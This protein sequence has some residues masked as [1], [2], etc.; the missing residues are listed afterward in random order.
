MI[1]QSNPKAAYLSHRA[2]IDAAI[3]RVLESGWYILGQEV[4]A[5]EREFAEY[6]GVAHA[7]GVA[8]GTD[9]LVLSLKACGVGPGDLV[10]TVAHTAVATVTAIDL[11]GA[12]PVF[13]D[14][15][16][17]TYNMDPQR[18]EEAIAGAVT[19]GLGLARAVIPVHL[20]GAAAPIDTIAQIARAYGLRLIEDCAQST[21][22]EFADTKTGA[23]GDLGAFSFYPT[24]NLGALGDGGMV[25]TNDDELAER[26][27][28]LR[29]YGW[30][31]RYV[32]ALPGTNSRLDEIQAA[33]LRAKL[34]FLDS[35]NAQRRHIADLY[36]SLLV[37]SGLTLPKRSEIAPSV[38]HQYVVQTEGRDSLREY[39]KQAG[40]GALIHY[41]VPVH[42]QPAYEAF[43]RGASLPHTERAARE[44][45][46]LP[47]YPELDEESVRE[48]ASQIL[49]WQR[50]HSS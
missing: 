38:F 44:V 39:L 36:D 6:I 19:S 26:V 15:D 24:K 37:T 1:L 16:P 49:S 2:E 23:W 20:Y 21:G 14:I 28:L 5:F 3:A 47:I 7:I 40:V 50:S 22:S 10:F 8:S 41:P 17:Q 25:T 35:A 11:C 34:P 48:T 31:E 18:L 4:A 29:E 43:G 13:V 30:K 45:L 33:I 27:R 46:S 12:A 32:S 42:R 9:A